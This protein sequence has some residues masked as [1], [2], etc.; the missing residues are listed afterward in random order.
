MRP[1]LW[2]MLVLAVV[3]GGGVAHEALAGG[4]GKSA[5]KQPVL[6]AS[7]KAAR[8]HLAET[9]AFLKKHRLSCGCRPHFPA[10][11]DASKP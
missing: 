11:A 10:A 1:R 2:L 9:A 4:D 6:T 5:P 7:Q 8:K 3:V